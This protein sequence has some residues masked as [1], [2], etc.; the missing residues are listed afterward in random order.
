MIL[1][2]W[3]RWINRKLNANIWLNGFY[4][5]WVDNDNKNQ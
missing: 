2:K 1:V 5:N 4:N 3:F